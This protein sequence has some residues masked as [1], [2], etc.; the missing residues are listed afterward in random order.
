MTD[1]EGNYEQSQI[2]SQGLSNIIAHIWSQHLRNL[3]NQIA[4]AKSE[5]S[6]NVSV[7]K[8]ILSISA[9]DE[10]FE[11]IVD[12]VLQQ[13]NIEGKDLNYEEI[14]QATIN[15]I[16]YMKGLK[17]TIKKAVSKYDALVVKEIVTNEEILDFYKRATNVDMQFTKPVI[18]YFY[19]EGDTDK[20]KAKKIVNKFVNIFSQ[21]KEDYKLPT[22]QNFLSNKLKIFRSQNLNKNDE[23]EI[24]ITGF[25]I[26]TVNPHIHASFSLQ[27]KFMNDE[28]FEYLRNQLHQGYVVNVFEKIIG[29]TMVLSQFVMGKDALNFEKS[30]EKFL[31]LFEGKIKNLTFRQLEDIKE[32]LKAE[33]E[34]AFT[35]QSSVAAYDSR[36][37]YSERKVGVN[38]F[39]AQCSKELGELTVDSLQSLYV[40]KVKNGSRVIFEYLTNISNRTDLKKED[41]YG[42]RKIEIQTDF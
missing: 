9:P 7:D 12:K 23:N 27:A 38:D 18:Q 2:K 10:I 26:G 14:S 32:N 25:Y 36:Q 34:T 40:D 3:N 11:R 5:V 20:D 19:I 42:D 13:I 31:S 33:Y 15:N 8:I 35:D 29:N 1:T 30:V 4:Y 28:A 22:V 41:L 21:D 6:V 16:R 37:T 39:R 24:Y 17:S